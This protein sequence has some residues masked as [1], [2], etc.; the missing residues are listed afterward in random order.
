MLLVAVD[1]AHSF[2]PKVVRPAWRANSAIFVAQMRGSAADKRS[3]RSEGNRKSPGEKGRLL[4]QKH[5]SDSTPDDVVLQ[6]SE[7]RQVDRF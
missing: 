5:Q 1:L 2:T 4:V 6:H 3:F 7:R